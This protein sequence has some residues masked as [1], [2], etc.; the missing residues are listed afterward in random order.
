MQVTHGI[1]SLFLILSAIATALGDVFPKSWVF[2]MLYALAVVLC[3]MNIVYAYCAKCPCHRY[4]CSHALFGWLAVRFTNRK[5]GRYTSLDI[6]STAISIGAIL[7]IPQLWLIQ[8][9]PSLVLFWSL[10]LLAVLDIIFLVCP[11]CANK[12][13]L[14]HKENKS[15]GA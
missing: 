15:L 2:G 8:S 4:G 1:I 13:C 3:T 14:L 9:I 7:L 12:Y 10:M 5:E 11:D 6:V